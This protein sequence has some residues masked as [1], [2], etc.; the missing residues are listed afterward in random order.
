MRRSKVNAELIENVRQ[1]VYGQ[2]LVL[3]RKREFLTFEETLIRAG[4]RTQR[5][6]V[7]WD[8]LKIE[9][10]KYFGLSLLSVNRTRFRDLTDVEYDQPLR[11]L[12]DVQKELHKGNGQETAGYCFPSWDPETTQRAITSRRNA[13]IGFDNSANRIEADQRIQI[14]AKGPI[15]E[16]PSPIEPDQAA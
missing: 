12:A 16:E 6:L 13:A 7:A 14:A 15:T 10:G 3:L 4:M 8:K 9:W 2:G 11:L 1:A 5:D